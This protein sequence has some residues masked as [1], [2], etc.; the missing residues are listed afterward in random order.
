MAKNLQLAAAGMLAVIS[1]LAQSNNAPAPKFDVASIKPNQSNDPPTSNFPLG[2]GDVYAR[3]GGLL[4]AT[5]FPLITYISFAYKIIGN[6]GQYLAPQLPDWAKTERYDIQAR[7]EHDPGKDGMRLM[8]RSLLAERC[9]LVMHYEDREVP[10]FAFVLV[11]G[12]KTGPE[13]HPHQENAE[14][15]TEGAAA[16]AAPLVGGK[17]A[18]CNGIYN[19][20]GGG[21]GHFR[22]GGRNVTI[23]FIADTFSQGTNLGRPMIDRTGL[24]GKFDFTL[25]W[26]QEQRGPVPPGADASSD[27]SGPSFEQALREQLGIK[28]QPQ[29]GTVRTLVLDHVERPSAN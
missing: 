11:K 26:T 22:F 16:T 20:P 29:K 25:E 13:L 7:A 12:G 28:L 8:M 19:L 9:K 4:S 3:N 1:I 6:Q 24:D 21:P 14:C 17:P 2:P 10:V 15:P 23:G 18:F 27:P 5:G